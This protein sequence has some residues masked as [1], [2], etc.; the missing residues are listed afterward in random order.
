M[1]R[2]FILSVCACIASGLMLQGCASA[3]EQ[4][5]QPTRT[6]SAA[7]PLS[8]GNEIAM[9]AISML[10]AP[11]KW[12]GAGPTDFDCSGLVRYIHAQVGIATP[13]TAAEQYTAAKRVALSHLEPGDLLFFHIKGSRISHV[14]IY[15][16]DGRFVHAPTTGRPV[17]LRM[18]DDEFYRPRLAGAGR[19]F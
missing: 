1:M 9:R 7:P 8:V 3:P 17:E 10:G 4:P 19:L 15:A 14:A 6:I 18:L 5:R 13:R 12:G 2:S 16:G 11:Y